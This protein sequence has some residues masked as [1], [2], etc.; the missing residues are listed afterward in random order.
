MIPFLN[1]PE[2][3]RPARWMKYPKGT[4][5][6]LKKCLYG[7]RTSPQAWRK[8]IQ[9]K[10]A[11][12]G[13]TPIREDQCFY[14][15]FCNGI[16]VAILIVHVDDFLLCGTDEVV[17]EVQKKIMEAWRSTCEINPKSYLGIEIV[18]DE[19]G[20]WVTLRHTSHINKFLKKIN[21]VHESAKNSPMTETKFKKKQKEGPT[22][23]AMEKE[24]EQR[25][26]E[27][28]GTLLY[29]VGTRPDIAYIVNILSQMI[30]DEQKDLVAKLI[31][32]L[33]RYLKGTLQKGLTYNRKNGLILEAAAD[34]NWTGD[35]GRSTTGFVITLGKMPIFFKSHL[36]KSVALSVHEAELVAASE[37]AQQVMGIRNILSSLHLT[38]L[39]P[40]T[41]DI[42]NK[43]TIDVIITGK[44]TDK[45]RH[46]EA[47]HYF[48]LEQYEKNN[49]D[50]RKVA[51]E[52]NKADG[53]TKALGP[54]KHQ[55][56]MKQLDKEDASARGMSI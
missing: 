20:E 51:T 15:R 33:G 32:R 21:I 23:D 55:L 9:P 12:W 14:A 19:T 41:I 47:R 28:V 31:H 53:L 13:F 22:T 2:Y 16:I 40:T 42:D 36:Q 50:V 49:V 38:P 25:M 43:S 48:I 45:T 37:A 5:L 26:H 54:R 27:I 34:A 8:E 52:N 1:Q 10:V 7:L 18:S 39:Q 3:V 35:K 4:V 46:I 44:R 17:A 11:A 56:W 6:K 29:I 30:K 24:Q